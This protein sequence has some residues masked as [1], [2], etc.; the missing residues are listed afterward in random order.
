MKNKKWYHEN[1]II[2]FV[3]IESKLLII[4]YEIN[5]FTFI[6]SLLCIKKKAN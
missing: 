6:K 2:Y 1:I 4:L 3:I 5:K